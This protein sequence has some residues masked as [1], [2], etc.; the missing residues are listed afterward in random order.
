MPR[1]I[2]SVKSIH[3]KIDIAAERN[4]HRVEFRNSAAGDCRF[5]RNGIQ[6]PGKVKV[7]GILRLSADLQWTIY[8][9]R[10]VTNR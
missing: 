6:H 1:M 4:I 9:R 2:G 3:H 10:V 8:T 7:G 5:D